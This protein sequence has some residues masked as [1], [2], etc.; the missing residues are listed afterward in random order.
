MSI[1]I[2]TGPPGAGKTTISK[3]FAQQ[4]PKCTLIE[5]DDLRH[6]VISPYK[7]PW[8]GEEGKKQLRLGIKNT[9]LLTKKF[10]NAGFNVIIADFITEYTFPIYKKLLEGLD[11]KIIQLTAQFDILKKRD[12]QRGQKIIDEEFKMLYDMQMKFT[13]YDLQIDNT[14]LSPQ[15]TTSELKKYIA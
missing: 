14:T 7:A 6:M 3:L 11:S 12:T 10:S 13:H 9:C 8:D 2:L 1:I 4:Q 15:E 5:T